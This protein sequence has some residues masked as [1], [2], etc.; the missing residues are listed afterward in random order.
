MKKGLSILLTLILAVM[1]FVALPM[2]VLADSA[3][4][5]EVSFTPTSLS[6]EG[7]IS[8][9]AV[10]TNKETPI[11]SATLSIGDNQV[12]DIGNMEANAKN[13][14]TVSYRVQESEIGSDIR[15]VLNYVVDGTAKKVTRTIQVAKQELK[16]DVYAKGEV[17]QTVVPKGTK[18]EFTFTVEN[19]GDSEIT[20]VQVKAAGVNKG[21]PID[22][23]FS[24]GAGKA[25]ILSYTGEIVKDMTV[26]PKLSYTAN[27][28]NYS[29]DL[30]VIEITVSE[31]ALKV[32]ISAGKN[33]VEA[34]DSVDISV[35]LSNEGNADIVNLVLYDVNDKKIPLDTST[36]AQGKSIS[37][38][39]SLTID[40]KT[41]IGFY[42]K[43]EDANGKSHT[44][45]SNVI[46]VDVT[47]PEE[48]ATPSPEATPD[49]DSEEEDEPLTID[50]TVEKPTDGTNTYQ[51]TIDIENRGEGPYTDAVLSES[52]LGNIQTIGDIAVGSTKVT[53]EKEI[54]GDSEFTFELTAKDPK[55]NTVSVK[56]EKLT[57][58]LNGQDVGNKT[59]PSSMISTLMIIIVIVI[60]LIVG[61]VVTLIVLVQKEKKK[62]A[63]LAENKNMKRP[64]QRT[65]QTNAVNTQPRVPRYAIDDGDADT[66]TFEEDQDAIIAG[67]QDDVRRRETTPARPE[68]RPVQ[69]KK[70]RKPTDFDDRN[71]F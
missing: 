58:V 2:A 61:V 9:T 26:K 33:Q 60:V 23:T 70:P 54:T 46:T 30:D 36:L 51:F 66:D 39:S 56:S 28:K 38:T 45:N 1:S 37:T 67:R 53:C 20:N 13:E 11:E 25:K 35:K 43:G 59:G 8:I 16:V 29:D 63:E 21:N 31:L 71:L 32:E 69:V 27:G 5:M 52:G 19:R 17:S 12:A 10:I 18:V 57:V 47:A 4:D 7:E 68:S 14:Q 62:K 3:P 15:V 6:G 24:L 49:G 34:G 50:A 42:V 22:G 44:F 48:T 41:D 55:G 65:V 40:K 64:G